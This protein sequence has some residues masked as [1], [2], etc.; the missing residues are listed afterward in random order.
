MTP[1]I[2]IIKKQCCY[3]KTETRGRHYIYSTFLSHHETQAV[4]VFPVATLD[5]KHVL[6]S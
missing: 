3:R 6:M 2:I 5:S 1:K 4:A